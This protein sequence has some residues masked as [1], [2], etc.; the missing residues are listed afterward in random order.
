MARKRH[1]DEDC[2]RLLREIE[3]HL[4]GGSDV[5]TACRTVGISD[6]TYYAWWKKFG[7]MGR[8]QL[9]ELKTIQREN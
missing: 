2:L 1:S 4:A 6:A 8:P 9:A 5:G 3:V 7:G